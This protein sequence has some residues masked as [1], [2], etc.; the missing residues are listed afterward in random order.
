L[1][2]DSTK[3]TRRKRFYLK[4]IETCMDAARL[5]ARQRERVME[6]GWS[7][8][9]LYARHIDRDNIDAWTEFAL[10]NPMEVVRQAA[11]RGRPRVPSGDRIR[12][13]LFRLPVRVRDELIEALQERGWQFEPDKKGGLPNQARDGDERAVRRLLRDAARGRR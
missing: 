4:H 7:K 3:I 12:T 6:P 8:V 1:K 9:R 11:E 5:G 10:A 13:I 2:T